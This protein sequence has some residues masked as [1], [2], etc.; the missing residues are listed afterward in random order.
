VYTSTFI[1]SAK[2]YDADFHRF[3]DEIAS[4]ARSLPGFLGEEEWHNEETGLHSE[5][6]YWETQEAMRELIAMPVHQE[7]KAQHERWIG[8]YRV[9]LSE[10]LTT[11]GLPG[12]GLQHQPT[13][14]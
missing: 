5:V 8:E 10:V 9:V 11:Y 12:L 1:F 6:Y 7:A 2:D 4:R 13:P 14:S 3:N